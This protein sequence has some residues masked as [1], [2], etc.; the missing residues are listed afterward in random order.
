MSSRELNYLRDSKE[1]IHA[2][3]GCDARQVHAAQAQFVN[4]QS[5]ISPLIEAPSD[6][7]SSA[8]VKSSR[9]NAQST[10]SRVKGVSIHRPFGSQ[11]PNFCPMMN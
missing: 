11:I 2:T 4:A 6:K 1:Y 3:E 8:S 9:R 7:V 5:H 10:K